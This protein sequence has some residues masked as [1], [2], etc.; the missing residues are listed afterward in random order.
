MDMVQK[1]IQGDKSQKQQKAGLVTFMTAMEGDS[2]WQQFY[3]DHSD[4]LLMIAE[5]W[6]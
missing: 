5:T 1:L 3:L 6:S 4:A 2:R